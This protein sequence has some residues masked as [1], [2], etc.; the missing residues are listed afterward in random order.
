MEEEGEAPVLQVGEVVMHV[1]FYEHGFGLSPHQFVRGL[2][3][4]YG[5]EI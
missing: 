1:S 5:L 3:F 2:L 4:F